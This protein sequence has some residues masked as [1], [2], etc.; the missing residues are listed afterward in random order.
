M[1]SDNEAEQARVK[2]E[3]KKSD[4]EAR[5]EAERSQKEKEKRSS[6]L[7]GQL[8]GEHHDMLNTAGT[9]SFVQLECHEDTWSYI[10]RQAFG[11]RQPRWTTSVLGEAGGPPGDGK[12]GHVP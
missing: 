4:Q 2:A 12:L 6:D 7:Y 1:P 10:A 5:A 8:H 9:V 3:Q 11:M